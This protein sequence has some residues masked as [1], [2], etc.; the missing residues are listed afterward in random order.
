ME[1]ARTL[2]IRPQTLIVS[3]RKVPCSRAG[4]VRGLAPLVSVLQMEF[5]KSIVDFPNIKPFP[6]GASN[7]M[8][9]NLQDPA[10]PLPL[11]D[12]KRVVRTIGAPD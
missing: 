5:D 7:D 10:N 9:P 6:G 4:M 11:M 12:I 8:V 2:A 1:V 3:P